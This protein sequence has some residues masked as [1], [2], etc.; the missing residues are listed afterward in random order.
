MT[1][2][3]SVERFTSYNLNLQ[4]NKFEMTKGVAFEFE[5]LKEGFA[6]AQMTAGFNMT[7]VNSVSLPEWLQ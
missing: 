1:V 5:L 3:P 2:V 7:Q 4:V 6:E